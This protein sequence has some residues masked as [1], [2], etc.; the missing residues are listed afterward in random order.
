MFVKIT[1]K[2]SDQSASENKG[3]ECVRNLEP[4]VCDQS[5]YF[6]ALKRPLLLGIYDIVL[7]SRA[8]IYFIMSKI[9]VTIAT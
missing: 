2:R 3:V 9:K 7:F 8:P 5:F 1:S 6:D 4:Q